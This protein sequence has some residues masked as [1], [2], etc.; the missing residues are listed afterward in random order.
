MK[1]PPSFA[2]VLG[3]RDGE[4]IPGGCPSCD[5]YQT[6]EPI[7]AGVWSLLVHHDE[8]CPVLAEHDRRMGRTR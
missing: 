7:T 8:G 6:F 2:N 5:A 4:K 3:P 1:V